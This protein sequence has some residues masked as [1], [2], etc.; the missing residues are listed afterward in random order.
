MVADG[1]ASIE[2]QTV[3]IDL[4][5]AARA[6][7]TVRY[8]LWLDYLHQTKIHKKLLDMTHHPAV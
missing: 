1:N 2:V 3:V 6:E 4:N 5:V 7:T 8:H